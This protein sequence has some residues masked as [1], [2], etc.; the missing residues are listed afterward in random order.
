MAGHGTSPFNLKE[1][2]GIK[3]I[4]KKDRDFQACLEVMDYL[5]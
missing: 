2:G 1:K 4:L 5:P 3:M